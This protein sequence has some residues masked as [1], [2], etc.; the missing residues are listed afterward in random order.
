MPP[1]SPTLKKEEIPRDL[2]STG[3]FLII[4]NRTPNAHNRKLKL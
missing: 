3:I 2:T 4:S 1:F